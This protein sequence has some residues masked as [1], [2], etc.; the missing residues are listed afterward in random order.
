MIRPPQELQMIACQMLKYMH[1]VEAARLTV[2]KRF[3]VLPWMASRFSAGDPCGS[4][5]QEAAAIGF[6]TLAD[7]RLLPLVIC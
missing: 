1:V 5:E 6:I 2:N 4:H 3:M 7:C